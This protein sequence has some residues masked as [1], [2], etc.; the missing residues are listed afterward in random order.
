MD[1][2]TQ[3]SELLTFFKALSNANRLK[4]I[5]LLANQPTTVEKLASQLNLSA[6]TVSHHLA[7][8]SD[9]GLVTA[10][11]EGYYSVYSLQTDVLETMSKKMLARE[12]LPTLAEDVDVDAYNRKVINEFT[13]PDGTIKAFPAQR[14]KMDVLLEYVVKSV[15]KDKRYTEKQINEV[16]K[17]YNE[18]Y[19]TLRRELI[20][21]KYM[22]R[23]NGEYWLTELGYNSSRRYR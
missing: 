21:I 12:N 10:K 6:P 18:D 22:A 5:G 16:L 2:S 17:T 7:R 1:E 4:I 23:Q 15:E 20:D 11:A 3:V 14:K 19:V 9:A 13:N 8:L